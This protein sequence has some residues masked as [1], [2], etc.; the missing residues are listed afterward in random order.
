MMSTLRGFKSLILRQY[1]ARNTKYVKLNNSISNML[2]IEIS[3]T[4]HKISLK[5]CTL[6]ND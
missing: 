2:I 6:V 4:F 1:F 3:A 5:I